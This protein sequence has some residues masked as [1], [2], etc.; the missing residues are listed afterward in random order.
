MEH[1]ADLG[2]DVD[3]PLVVDE[4]VRGVCGPMMTPAM[5]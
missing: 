3:R 4:H 5:M 1:H 2:E